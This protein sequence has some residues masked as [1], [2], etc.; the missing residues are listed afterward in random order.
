[1]RDFI[2]GILVASMIFV[3]VGYIFLSFWEE[4]L[5]NDVQEKDN[6]KNK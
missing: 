3:C 2:L 4:Q 5:R 1:M 6:D